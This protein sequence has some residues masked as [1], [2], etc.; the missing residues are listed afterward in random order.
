MEP[1]KSGENDRDREDPN[2]DMDA[3]RLGTELA[4]EPQVDA[5]DL[6]RAQERAG[7][8]ARYGGRDSGLG[9][10]GTNDEEE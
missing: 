8:G 4:R 3:D 6:Q 2:R 9:I 1:K 5:G 7:K 10:N